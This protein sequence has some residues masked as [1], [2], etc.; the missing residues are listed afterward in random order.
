MTPKCYALWQPTAG[1]PQGGE[2]NLT[3]VVVAKNTREQIQLLQ[4]LYLLWKD[5]PPQLKKRVIFTYT[6]FC[7]STQSK[8]RVKEILGKCL[9]LSGRKPLISSCLRQ[10]KSLKL[11]KEKQ[12]RGQEEECQE[13]KGHSSNGSS[14]TSSVR[15]FQ[16]SLG[17]HFVFC[18]METASPALLNSWVLMRSKWNIGHKSIL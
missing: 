8:N 7:K 17:L 6:I 9:Y 15:S 13:K 14:G 18:R 2:S 11:I 12:F 3:V 10:E 1:Q 16:M 5:L 4:G